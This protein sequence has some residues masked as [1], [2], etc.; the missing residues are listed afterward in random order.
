MAVAAASS[1]IATGRAS[2]RGSTSRTSTTRTWRRCGGLLDR[3]KVL[4]AGSPACRAAISNSSAW[5]SAARASLALLPYVGERQSPAWRGNPAEG[6]RGPR[7]RRRRG[8]RLARLPAQL[9]GPAQARAARHRCLAAGGAA[10]SRGGRARR[11]GGGRPRRGDRGAARQ[12]GAHDPAPRRRGRQAL[13]L[14][15]QRGDRRG[16]LQ[17][18]GL[19]VDRKKIRLEEPIREV[20]T[21]MIEIEVSGGATARVKTIVER[22]SRGLPAISSIT[23][24]TRQERSRRI[25][26]SIVRDARAEDAEAMARV[27]AAVAE[28]GIDRDR[29]PCRRRRPCRPVSSRSSPRARTPSG[30]SR[31]TVGSS[32]TQ[33]CKRPA[34]PVFSCS[35]FPE[36]RG[37]GGG[38]ALLEAMIEHAHATGSHKLELEV[39]PTTPRPSLSTSRRVRGGGHAPR[40]P[41]PARRVV[42]LG[43][44]DGSA[45]RPCSRDV[46]P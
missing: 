31:T 9:P 33:E 14:G 10:P 11:P 6:C 5:R 42:A 19:R 1:V 26:V 46:S 40:P 15:H 44:V 39:W 27:I 16:D 36:A 8:R 35:A 45:G 41:P 43:S 20:G 22:S 3:G 25:P 7:R 23:G 24:T 32:A 38:R 18:R 34:L 37:L 4:P 12:D 13:R 2:T 17:A 30:R 29:A 21:Y 28:E